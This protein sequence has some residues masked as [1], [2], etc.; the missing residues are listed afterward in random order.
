MD[1]LQSTNI[2][3]K[4]SGKVT[5][6]M[7][8]IEEFAKGYD[9]NFSENWLSV[10]QF[11]LD[12]FTEKQ[13]IEFLFAL[14][15][16]SF[17][18]WKQPRWI[19]SYEGKTYD[20][21][22]GMIACLG[23]LMIQEPEAFE[24]ENLATMGEHKLESILAGKNP[25]PLFRE[26][27]CFIRQLGTITNNFYDGDFRNIIDESRYSAYRLSKRLYKSFPL[28]RD[29]SIYNG[30][31]VYFKKRAQLLAADLGHVLG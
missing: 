28:F 25:I 8:R 29:E 16:I 11:N 20:G 4:D 10:A 9:K 31:T 6:D 5:L 24:P 21:A 23:R 17:C 22:K 7:N 2:V 27:L 26:R 18:Y 12:H 14:D 3:V 19:V 15:S 13:K 30:Q 1:V